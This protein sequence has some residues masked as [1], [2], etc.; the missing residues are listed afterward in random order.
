MWQHVATPPAKPSR[1][2]DPR[3]PARSRELLGRLKCR[4]GYWRLGRA[5]SPLSL[6]TPPGV[7]GPRPPRPDF[8]GGQI[9]EG[10]APPGIPGPAGAA[11]PRAQRR[12]PPA[13]HPPPPDRGAS[14]ARDEAAARDPR[15][16]RNHPG[17]GNRNMAPP[18]LLELRT[19]ANVNC[20]DRITRARPASTPCGAGSPV[21]KIG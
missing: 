14:L 8:A 19:L 21:K 15:G 18:S 7:A 1:R 3:P 10:G 11:G 4:S 17:E 9:R 6:L 12:V 13:E 16:P 2:P 5:R 20:T